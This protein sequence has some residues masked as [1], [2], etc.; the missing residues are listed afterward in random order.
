MP[1]N[2]VD[3]FSYVVNLTR[4]GSYRNYREPFWPPATSWNMVVLDLCNAIPKFGDDF[5]AMLAELRVAIDAEWDKAKDRGIA[6]KRRL[7]DP[8]V[9][10]AAMR[11]IAQHLP[12]DV[13]T[14]ALML[15]ADAVE[16]GYE[17]AILRQLTMHEEDVTVIAGQVSTWYGKDVRGL[18]TAFACRRDEQR[19]VDVAKALE[20]LPDVAI[21]LSRLHPDLGLGDL[22]AFGACQL[23]FMAGEGNLHPKHI[24]YFL[25]EDEGVKHSTFKKT[26]YFV[27]THRALV[28]NVSAPLAAD[29]LA[30]DANLE[31]GSPRF[32]AVPTL[33]VL[34][35]EF[36]HFVQRP[37]TSFKEL[38][39]ADRWASV[40]LQEVAADVFGILVLADVWAE[41][42]DIARGDVIAYY[43]AECLRYV[44]R[45]L[46]Y[47]PDSDG[48]YLQLSYLVQLGALEWDG[49]RLVGNHSAVIAGLRSLARVLA[50][51]LLAGKVEPTVRL[52]KA[53]GSATEAPLRALIE[54]LRRR[55]AVSVEYA[56]DGKTVFAEGASRCG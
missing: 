47:F 51:F 45:G 29:L 50:D 20:L 31:P 53:Y 33:G 48:M 44:S 54:V 14:S 30:L 21:Y 12:S 46:G 39:A 15:R 3:R 49:T 32:D 17:D 41:S 34:S 37:A 55:P 27:N 8:A 25:P 4:A 43:L 38:N 9:V 26:Y 1:E 36:G 42:L 16:H 22:P 56:Q 10:A 7:A 13:D 52:Y 35:H 23:F 5:Q 19:Q 18:P 2:E 6:V 24:A 40:V 28:Q 11:R